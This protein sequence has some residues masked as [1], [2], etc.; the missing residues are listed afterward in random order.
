MLAK[1]R[2]GGARYIYSIVTGDGTKPPDGLTVPAGK[3]YDP[4]IAGDMGAY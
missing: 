2:E 1:A 4:Y 3:Y